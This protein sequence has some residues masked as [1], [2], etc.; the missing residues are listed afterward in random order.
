MPLGVCE[1]IEASNS[2]E[3]LPHTHT[4]DE[5]CM[6]Q[7]SCKDCIDDPPA[8]TD[9]KQ[10]EAA[11]THF[12]WNIDVLLQKYWSKHLH[13]SVINMSQVTYSLHLSIHPIF[14]SQSVYQ[15]LWLLII[16]V[17]AV[18]ISW[19]V[20]WKHMPVRDMEAERG[21]EASRLEERESEIW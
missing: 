8:D 11:D 1:M 18:N 4:Q 16:D 13:Y 7:R 2:A 9:D 14:V 21:G 12:I 6:L 19:S 10:P 3:S 17:F 5:V 20:D 15:I